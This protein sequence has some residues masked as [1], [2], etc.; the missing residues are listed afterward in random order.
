MAPRIWVTV[1]VTDRA[2]GLS[3]M[4]RDLVAQAGEVGALLTVLVVENSADGGH[5]S[6]NRTTAAWMRSQ[7]V[8]VHLVDEE[9]YRRSIAVSRTRQR[10]WV[11]EQ[12]E[13]EEPPAFIWM[14][15]D[16]NRLDH[17][18]F[19]GGLRAERLEHH[20]GRLLDLASGEPPDLLIGTV[21]GDPPIPPSATY[22]SRLA[23][24]CANLERLFAAPPNSPATSVLADLRVV[25]EHDDYYDFSL[26]RVAPSWARPCR[27]LVRSVEE[28]V[29]AATDALLREA[30]HIG[31]GG[32]LTRPILTDSGM[33]G[34]EAPGYRRGGNAVFFSPEACVEHQYPSL[35][36][37]GVQTRRGDMIGSRLL[38]ENHRVVVSGFSVRHCR[39]RST[40]VPGRGSLERSILADNLGAA[41]ARGVA[42]SDPHVA[43]RAFLD[44]RHRG[45]AAAMEAASRWADEVPRRLEQAPPWVDSEVA[46][47]VAAVCRQ[48]RGS[49]PWS[50]R[51][52]SGWLRA[53]FES[54]AVAKSLAREAEMQQARAEE[55]A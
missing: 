24:L 34:A 52:I 33:L 39:S 16:D 21:T 31:S 20:L 7:G 9:P 55:P 2:D 3:V 44:R 5:R 6:M 27:W 47:Q 50:D 43:V 37:E 53:G 22:A 49:L 35:E 45:V 29:A 38:A 23:D 30:R 17:L 54:E 25:S 42:V 36:I 41:L 28:T 26:E 19:D 10:D 4:M 32:A 40:S 48:L 1:A 14:L 51:S 18:I 13:T 15:D 8:A 12:L 11:C 46:A